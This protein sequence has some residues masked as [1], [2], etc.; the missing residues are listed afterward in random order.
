L[1]KQQEIKKWLEHNF[2]E[3]N[4]RVILDYLTIQGCVIKVE[5]YVS[6]TIV[7]CPN[8]HCAFLDN[9]EPLIKECDE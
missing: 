2:H 1:N 4:A 9:T 5:G 3:T 7:N 8:C 6:G